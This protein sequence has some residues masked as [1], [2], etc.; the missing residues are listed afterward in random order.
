MLPRRKRQDRGE[1]PMIELFR[2]YLDQCP[3]VA[4]IRGVTPPE[5]EAIGQAV[6]D[7]GIRI[8]EVPLNSPDPIDS[9]GRLA[10]K[11]GDSM[12]VGGGTV[13]EPESVGE[14][15]AV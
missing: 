5:A 14:I 13:L 11:F 3:L 1:N 15:K 10:A 9:I 12:L 8:I 6:Y 2:G 4:I 7:A